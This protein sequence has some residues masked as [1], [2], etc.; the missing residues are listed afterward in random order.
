MEYVSPCV[1]L[2]GLAFIPG[3]TP[4][5]LCST[6]LRI[7][8]LQVCPMPPNRSQ[9]QPL[10]QTAEDEEEDVS[11]GLAPHRARGLRRAQRPVHI[12]LSKLDSA[13][14]RYALI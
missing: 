8:P 1:A 6:L 5:S 13:F 4:H 2:S 14:K 9:Y 7:R 3:S 12:D 11:E 10:A